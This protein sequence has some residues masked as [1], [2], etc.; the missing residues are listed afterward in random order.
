MRVRATLILSMACSLMLAASVSL[1]AQTSGEGI[2][3]HVDYQG[4]ATDLGQF[5]VLTPSVGYNFDE[6]WGIDAGIPL[7][8]VHPAPDTM[9]NWRTWNHNVGDI[10]VDGRLSFPNEMV[11]YS[12][13]LTVSAP[14]G[15]FPRGFSTGRVTA[16]WYNH[17]DRRFGRVTPFADASLGNTLA[18][19]HNLERPFRTLGWVSQF[20]GGG[21]YRVHHSFQVGASMYDV[22]PGG[23]QKIYSQLF[24]REPSF[25][26]LGFVPGRAQANHGR[27]FETAFDTTGPARIARDNGYSGWLQFNPSRYVSLEGGYTRSVRYAFDTVYFRV[28]VNAKSVASQ[29]R[30]HF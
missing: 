24:M 10:F 3:A 23:T 6:H 12:S 8:F 21:T 25:A 13:I 17:F 18:D 22:L 5:T 11:N 30:S 1:R 16:D 15:S 29:I 26:F 14:T 19:R 27:V 9:T 20:E 7:Y 28:G 4:S 2:T